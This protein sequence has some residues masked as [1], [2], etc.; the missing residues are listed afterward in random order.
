MAIQLVSMSRPAEDRVNES[1]FHYYGSLQS[2]REFVLDNYRGKITLQSA[3]RIAHME[4]TYFSAFF[5]RKVG[6]PFRDWLRTLRI[7]RAQELLRESNQPIPRVASAVGFSQTR[8]FE[9][10][11]KKCSRLTPIQYRRMMRLGR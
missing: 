7:Q 6:V 1:A 3:A 11:F 10:A 2:V 9:R 8:S 4:R 5:H